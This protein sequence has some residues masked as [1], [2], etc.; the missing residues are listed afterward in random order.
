MEYY[1][2]Q[3]CWGIGLV[4]DIN[5]PQQSGRVKARIYGLHTAD[6][7]KLP[8]SDLPWSQ[9][10]TPITSASVSGKG[11]SPVGLK[12]GSLVYGVFLDPD[13]KQQF[14]V[15]GSLAGPRNSS[16]VQQTDPGIESSVSDSELSDFGNSTPEAIYNLARAKGLTNIQAAGLVGVISAEV[17]L[18]FDSTRV[19]NNVLG[20]G[21]FESDDIELLRTYAAQ[22]NKPVTDLKTQ[23]EFICDRLLGNYAPKKSNGVLFI[24]EEDYSSIIQRD[25]ENEKD[26]ANGIAQLFFK[27]GNSQRRS[28][29]QYAQQAMASFGSTDNSAF[30][31]SYTRRV[32]PSPAGLGETFETFEELVAY[33]EIGRDQRTTER[34][35]IRGLIVHHTDTYENMNTDAAE[36]DRWHKQK[37][38][39]EIGYHFVIRRDGSITKGRDITKSGAHTSAKDANGRGFNS[40]TIGIAFVGGL[41]G[42]SS[43]GGRQR[44]SSTFTIAQWNAFDEFIRA[45]LQVF[46]DSFVRGHKDVQPANRT[47]PEFDVVQ[48]VSNKYPQW[49]GNSEQLQPSKLTS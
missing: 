28:R 29:E 17:N 4:E 45:W 19:E 46:P 12:Q 33:F 34:N 13:M 36:I 38:F 24:F 23:I 22:K 40:F 39:S 31:G 14:L 30:T 7:S 47:D 16:Q 20:I 6:N 44:S 27:Q 1:G 2:S 35:R 41:I 5:D 3:F 42:D 25:I 8:T 9:V 18:N 15:L 37:G 11:T 49:T 48:Y 43:A 21:N 10:M 32:I 26:A